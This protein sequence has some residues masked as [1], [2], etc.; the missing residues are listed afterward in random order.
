MPLPPCSHSLH[1][2]RFWPMWP[3]CEYA[4]LVRIAAANESREVGRQRI[5]KAGNSAASR[6]NARR[7]DR[8]SAG[9]ARAKRPTQQTAAIRLPKERFHRPMVA[10]SGPS[11]RQIQ[12]STTCNHWSRRL[13]GLANTDRSVARCTEQRPCAKSIRCPIRITPPAASASPCCPVLPRR[14]YAHRSSDRHLP[15]Y[16][17]KRFLPDARNLEQLVDAC[18]TS[19][20]RTV[21]DDFL[22]HHRADAFDLLKPRAI[23]SVDIDEIG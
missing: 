22:R 23:G 7:C 15:A 1:N 12:D 17:L 8:T 16:L 13:P 10:S 6:A 3:E 14:E 18:E 11:L 9:I 5:W 19:Y 4:S 20:R 21:V 2:G